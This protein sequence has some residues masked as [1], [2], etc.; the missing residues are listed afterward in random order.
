MK[1]D[2]KII[3]ECIINKNEREMSL[4]SNFSLPVSIY[5]LL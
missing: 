5:L 3:S 1:L 4:I 2:A